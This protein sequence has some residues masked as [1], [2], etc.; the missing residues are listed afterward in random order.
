M[1]GA[2]VAVLVFTLS[3]LTYLSWRVQQLE[4]RLRAV[5]ERLSAEPAKSADP[6]A[7]LGDLRNPSPDAVRRAVEAEPKP[8][9]HGR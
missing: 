5:E 8:G 9:P 6:L 3:A 4:H 1:S 7:E 2:E